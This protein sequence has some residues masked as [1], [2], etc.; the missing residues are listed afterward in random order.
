MPFDPLSMLLGMPGMAPTMDL[1]GGADPSV[2]GPIRTMFPQI[3]QMY[4]N[5]AALPSLENLIGVPQQHP[6]V[7]AA[8]N[9]WKQGMMT[10]PEQPNPLGA[11]LA[12]MAGNIGDV[13]RGGGSQAGAANAANTIS[14]KRSDL[15]MKRLD[16]LS[17]LEAA[18]QK[19]AKSAEGVDEGTR[20][21][22]LTKRDTMLKQIEQVSTSLREL[23]VTGAQISA[24][25]QRTSAEL[26]SAERRAQMERQTQIDVAKI[27]ANAT[28]TAAGLRAGGQLAVPAVKMVDY[29]RAVAAYQKPLRTGK[30]QKEQAG[31]REERMNLL[32]G[33][34]LTPI[35][36]E[37]PRQAA[38]RIA[39]QL[40]TPETNPKKFPRLPSAI[41]FSNVFAQVENLPPN[42]QQ[43][44]VDTLVNQ[45][46]NRWKPFL[47][48][49]AEGRP[50]AVQKNKDA[51]AAAAEMQTE[52]NRLYTEKGWITK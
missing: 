29:Q 9:A 3:R 11:G 10:P 1:V 28:T 22:L 47:Q 7:E 15:L 52:A 51:A 31:D 24:A 17:A 39:R 48:F 14:M 33:A 4:E 37:G 12:T 45:F 36:G 23:G 16:N 42:E 13:L 30:N 6:E 8:F 41:T 18:Y 44:F 5:Q 35:I 50:L 43:P 49:D 40:P 26:G 19:A 2:M 25:N 21:Q 38:I 34:V 46:L 27:H 32:G 20:L